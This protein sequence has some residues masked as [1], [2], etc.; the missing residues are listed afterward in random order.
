MHN[1]ISSNNRRNDVSFF[2]LY[3]L[4]VDL[5]SVLDAVEVIKGNRQNLC[6]QRGY[7][8]SLGKKINAYLSN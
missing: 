7:V 3:L 8:L 1:K 4:N 5:Y 2:I 6:L